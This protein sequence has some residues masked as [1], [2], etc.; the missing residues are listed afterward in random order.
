MDTAKVD[1]LIARFILRYPTA[2]VPQLS[3][4]DTEVCDGEWGLLANGYDM[5]TMQMA[6][7]V[8]EWLRL[9]DAA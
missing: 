9:E 5:T 4:V 8:N 1:S 6:W 2:T 7:L 3:T